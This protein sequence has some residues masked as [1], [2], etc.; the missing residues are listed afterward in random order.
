MKYVQYTISVSVSVEEP[1]DHVVYNSDK[2]WT[3]EELYEY[4]MEDRWDFLADSLSPSDWDIDVRI[5]EKDE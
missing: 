3:E 1:L 5:I 2:D 4:I